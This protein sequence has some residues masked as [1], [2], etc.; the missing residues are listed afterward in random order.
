MSTRAAGSP[1]LLPSLPPS[2]T[3]EDISRAGR[4]HAE[5]DSAIK[6][7]RRRSSNNKGKERQHPVEASYADGGLQDEDESGA[8]VEGYP[9]IQEDEAETRRVE[10]NLRRW[11]MAERQRRKAARESA[12]GTNSSTT[13][14]GDV[15]RRASLLWSGRSKRPSLGGV[16]T[17]HVLRNTDDNGMPMDN[18]DS[19]APS[20]RPSLEATAVMSESTEPSAADKDNLTASRNGKATQK[21][22]SLAASSTS[23]SQLPPPPQPLDLPKPRSP[24]PRTMTPHASRPPEPLPPPSPAIVEEEDIPSRP[25]RW[26]TDWLCGC[27]ESG[28]RQAGRTNPFE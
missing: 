21:R 24:P 10:E 23:T 8:P 4:F 18:I 13:L 6:Q 22:S 19:P 9:P 5:A 15:T 2:P 7:E 1:E 11:E 17:H 14:V 27:I 28:D 26:W 25:T 12:L 20:A 3:E 16:G